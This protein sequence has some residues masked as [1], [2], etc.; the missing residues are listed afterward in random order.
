MLSLLLACSYVTELSP[1]A[2]SQ[3][4]FQDLAAQIVTRGVQE[5]DMVGATAVVIVDGQLVAQVAVGVRKVGDP[6]PLQVTDPMHTGSNTKGMTS[7]LAGRLVEKG[8][9]SW[10][11]TLGQ[12]LPNIPDIDPQFLAV[13]LIEFLWQR[14][15]I[16]DDH[17]FEKR[18]LEA[19]PMSSARLQYVQT[20]T[21]KSPSFRPGS[22]H[23]YRNA[24]FIAAGCML[25]RAGGGEW[26][27]L[28]KSEVFGPLGMTTAGFGPMGNGKDVSVPWQHVRK[29]GE[30]SPV[31]H[32][33]PRY[34]GPAG[35]VHCS[36]IDLAKYAYERVLG[37][38]G[39]SRFLQVQTWTTLQTP[40]NGS[41]Y[42][43]GI[44]TSGVGPQGIRDMSHGGS[45]NMSASDWW[46][47]N[48]GRLI[49]VVM[50]NC[51]EGT[52]PLLN[53]LM[54]AAQSRYRLD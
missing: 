12:T 6:T 28:M 51:P 24:N 42:A 43:A 33:N 39:R 54:I 35:T 45:N 19:K 44:S 2:P 21:S 37:A 25:E 22:K 17:L 20:L 23:E 8:K 9:I 38:Y 49:V 7:L 41:S 4:S 30:W 29:E 15:G 52:G 31:H 11:S 40:P 36:A 34:F 32:D 27:D 10:Q 46:V 47:R 16:S 14:T 18:F 1:T 3:R 50:S 48:Q 5:N 53:D 13:P 26:E